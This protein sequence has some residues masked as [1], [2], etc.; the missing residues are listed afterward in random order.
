MACYGDKIVGLIMCPRGR[1]INDEKLPF[2]VRGPIL[3]VLPAYQRVGIGSMSMRPDMERA[4][5]PRLMPIV[6]FG[7][8]EYY[9]RFG[10]KNARNYGVPTSDGRNF[11]ACFSQDGQEL[12][13]ETGRLSIGKCRKGT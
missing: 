5:A 3:G 4:R 1:I 10:L 12:L 6:L 2:T 9:P 11:D 7:S 13:G 8:Q